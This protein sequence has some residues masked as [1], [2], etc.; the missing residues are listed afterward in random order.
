[1]C[2][3]KTSF[4]ADNLLLFGHEYISRKIHWIIN[5]DV[6]TSLSTVSKKRTPPD[7]GTKTHPNPGY[8]VKLI[9]LGLF[10]KFIYP[11][12]FE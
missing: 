11:K 7:S 2:F 4:E 1:M 12:K 5:Y 9:F 6:L 10:N 8:H 3:E